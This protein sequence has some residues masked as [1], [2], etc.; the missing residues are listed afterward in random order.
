MLA[1]GTVEVNTNSEAYYLNDDRYANVDGPEG[2]RRDARAGRRSTRPGAS[3]GTTTGCTG[4]RRATPPQVNDK[5]A[6]TKIFDYRIPVDDRRRGAARSPARSSGR[7][8]PAAGLPLGAIFAFAAIIIAL[9]IAVVA[10]RRAAGA[11]GA[12]ERPAAEAW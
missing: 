6:R 3:S 9:C 12:G 11:A 4:W 2:A 8:C 5:D 1:D 7:R 10:V